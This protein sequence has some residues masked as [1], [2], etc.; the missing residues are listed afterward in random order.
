MKFAS[1]QLEKILDDEAQ[2][3]DRRR[4]SNLLMNLS[5]ERFRAGLVKLDATSRQR[6]IGIISHPMDEDMRVRPDEG[7]GAK[8]KSG[9]SRVDDDHGIGCSVHLDPDLA[10]QKG[11][12]CWSGK[13]E[14]PGG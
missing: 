6:P 10:N 13:H 3:T 7:A 14:C 1:G 11:G 8:L 5:S 2:W 4:T 9:R 12:C